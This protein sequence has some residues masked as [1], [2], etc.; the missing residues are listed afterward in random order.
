M[1]A[2]DFVEGFAEDDLGRETYD[3]IGH[4]DED[5]QLNFADSDFLNGP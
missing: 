4:E 3:E 5:A 2:V 1:A